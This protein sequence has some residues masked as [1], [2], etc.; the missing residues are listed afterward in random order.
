V[1]FLHLIIRENLPWY[2]QDIFSGLEAYLMM[3][4]K[5]SGFTGLVVTAPQQ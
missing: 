3:N 1:N 5:Y 2:E 4:P